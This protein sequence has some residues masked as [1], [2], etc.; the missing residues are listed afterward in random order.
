MSVRHREEPLLVA[1]GL[2]KWYGRNLGC[3]AGFLRRR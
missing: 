3:R 2:T 1:E